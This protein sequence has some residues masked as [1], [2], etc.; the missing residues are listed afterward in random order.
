MI[1]TLSDPQQPEPQPAPAK[2]RPKKKPRRTP[3]PDPNPNPNPDPPAR[4]EPATRVVPRPLSC[5]G[6]LSAAIHHLRRSDPLL[7]PLIDSHPAPSLHPF[8]PPFLTLA[9]S[10]LHQ[11]LAFKAAASAYSRFLSLC[12]GAEAHVTPAAVL[13]LSVPD[14]RNIGISKRK[15]GYLHDLAKKFHTGLLSDEAILSMDDKSVTSLLTMVEGIGAWSVHMFLI[16]SLHRPDVLPVG[17]QGVRKGVQMLYGLEE[18]PRPS[19][20]ERLCERWRPYRSVGSWY[21]WRLSEGRGGLGDGTGQLQQHQQ[22]QQQ[23]HPQLLLDN[24]QN[25][26]NPRAFEQGMMSTQAHGSFSTIHSVEQ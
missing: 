15:A 6:E 18:T 19:Q 5:P 4:A 14:L 7:C 8:L 9:R 25:I 20:M 1:E 3:L 13:S 24:G 12:G 21:M 2:P 23:Y 10:I 22:Q 17:D 26:C 16:F 11:Q